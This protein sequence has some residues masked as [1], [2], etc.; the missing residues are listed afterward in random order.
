MIACGV[1]LP[2]GWKQASYRSRCSRLA[3]R[4][5]NA[6]SFGL[7]RTTFGWLSSRAHRVVVPLFCAP[8]T[9]ILGSTAIRSRSGLSR[10]KDAQDRR[11]GAVAGPAVFIADPFAKHVQRLR[12]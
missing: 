10:L 6:G 11:G 5:K 9:K 8:A 3:P 7:D 2:F 12:R 4:E 1:A